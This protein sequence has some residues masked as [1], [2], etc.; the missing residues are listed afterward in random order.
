[1]LDAIRPLLDPQRWLDTG[2]VPEIAIRAAV[3]SDLTTTDGGHVT[4]SIGIA[5]RPAPGPV[6]WAELMR[7][8]DRAVYCAK[9]MGRNRVEVA[10]LGPAKLPIHFS[11]APCQTAAE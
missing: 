11:P 9:A 2:R 7:N 6:D 8:A 10:A 3:A 4:V 1:M 5:P